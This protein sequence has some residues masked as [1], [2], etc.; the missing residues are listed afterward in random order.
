MEHYLIVLGL[1]ESN[2]TNSLLER[3]DGIGNIE[4]IFDNMYILSTENEQFSSSTIRD[5][6]AGD[7]RCYVLVI[8]MR[9]NI[10][11]AWCLPKDKV[12]IINDMIKTR[13]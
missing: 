3:M 9:Q 10:E 13:S 12:G 1:Y 4:N 7:E 6:I 11:A 5:V 2:I 8:R